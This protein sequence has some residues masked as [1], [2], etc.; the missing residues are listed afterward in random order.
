MMLHNKQS[1][2]I[3]IFF[4]RRIMDREKKQ[5]NFSKKIFDKFINVGTIV[6]EQ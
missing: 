3:L 2:N 1:S 5:Y 6:Y 4:F